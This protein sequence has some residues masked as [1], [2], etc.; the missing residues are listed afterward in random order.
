MKIILK[1]IAADDKSTLGKLSIDGGRKYFTL[2]DEF[3]REKVKGET[4]IPAGVYKIK[5]RT[6][7]GF[8]KR[9]AKRFGD[10]HQGMLELQNVP[11]F[12]Y[13]LIHCGND[14][15]DTAGCIL[16]G[17]SEYHDAA[18]GYVVNSSADAYRRIYPPVAAALLA[19][20]NVTI[21]ITDP[22]KKTAGDG[23]GDESVK[24]DTAS[25]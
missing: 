9:Y 21:E 23:P 20:E 15:E 6:T 17:L 22:A 19:G 8:D 10:M 18:R 2:E 25:K 5:L 12:K 11:G 24:N 3:R 4:R 7:G 16:V 13:I 1:R 14:H